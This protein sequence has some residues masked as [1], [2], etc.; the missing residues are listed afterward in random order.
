MMKHIIISMIILITTNSVKADNYN[1]DSVKKNNRALH[2]NHMVEEYKTRSHQINTQTN[3]GRQE[4]ENGQRELNRRLENIER[5]RQFP[6]LI[7][8]D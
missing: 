5:Q 7:I 8:V 2:L 3:V 6:D 1:L 4:Y